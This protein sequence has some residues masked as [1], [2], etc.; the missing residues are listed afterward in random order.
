MSFEELMLTYGYPILFLG[1][2]L[3]GE[4]FLIA[5]AYL[6]H[7]G[8]FSLPAV[9]GI[10][11]LS[12]FVVTQI[13]FYLGHRY[14]RTFIEKRPRWQQRF[15]RVERLLHKYGAGLL[16]VFRALYGLRAV[17]PA[18]VGL[19]RYPLVKFLVLNAVG[20][21]V[22]ALVIALAGNGI[23]QVAEEL[24]HEIRYHERTVFFVVAG[25]GVL[26]GLY[27]LYRQPMLKK[28]ARQ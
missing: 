26:W 19:S 3:E 1:V 7:R 16:L 11:V 13:Y 24:F 20:A 22:W 10:A 12:S 21:L 6:A 27:Q 28:S 8:Y 4:A 18:A 25:L 15:D 23:A 14:G 2:M 17:I 9:I 5:G